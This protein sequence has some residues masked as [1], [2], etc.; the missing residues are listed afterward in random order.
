MKKN[1]SGRAI[2]DMVRQLW[3]ILDMSI[4]PF[5]V[6]FQLGKISEFVGSINIYVS[7]KKYYRLAQIFVFTIK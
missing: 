5:Y 7:V 6:N 3:T 4:A 1:N 2:L